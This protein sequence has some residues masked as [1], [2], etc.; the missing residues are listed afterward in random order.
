M[1]VC[2]D[3]H[4]HISLIFILSADS[5]SSSSG[6]SVHIDP[7]LPRKRARGGETDPGEA[8]EWYP[9]PDRVVSLFQLSS[10]SV[11]IKLYQSCTLDL[12]M[13]LPRSSFSR[14]QLDLFLWLLRVNRVND[15]PSTKSSKTMQTSIQNLCGIRTLDYDG[16][17]GHRYHV[18]SLA[19]ILAQVWRVFFFISKQMSY[20]LFRK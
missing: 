14:K 20:I 2:F 15:V 8:R 18:N 13:H 7:N 16:K 9:W 11:N 17:L 4:L 12:L 10:L 3:S 19:Q 1:K 5:S 6:Y